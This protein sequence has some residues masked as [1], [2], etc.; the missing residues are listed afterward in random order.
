MNPSKKVY[1]QPMMQ[2]GNRTPDPTDSS[3]PPTGPEVLRIDTIVSGGDGITRHP[4]GFVV[5]V[6]RT[7]AGEQVEVNYIE[8]HKQ[9]RRARVIRVLESSPHRR[10]PPCPYYARCGGCQLQ[11]LDYNNAQLPAKA[12]IIRDSLRR[13]GKID[14]ALPEVEASEHEFG[15]R[16]RV[17]LELN[18]RS[19]EAVAGYHDINY[20]TV[21][22]G[23]DECP[24]AE[25][26]IND[27]WRALRSIWD[28]ATD[29]LPP[30]R[31]LRLTFRANSEG[32]VGLAIEGGRGPGRCGELLDITGGLFAVWVLDPRG[33]IT[34]RA[35][36]P[37]L[38][39]RIGAYT[40]PLAG[41]GF[42]QV[43]RETA[44]R[45]DSY[46]RGQC[47]TVRGGRVVDAYCGY[48]IR[49]LELARDGASVVG[50]EHD[51]Y[52]VKTANQI[53]GQNGIPARFVMGDVERFLGRFTPADT[54]IV[55]PP[56]RGVTRPVID[57]LMERDV[58]RIVY[59]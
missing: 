23:I 59:V 11:H 53:A 37:F 48:G 54:V 44:A 35:G 19:C 40:V 43:N 27:A 38:D 7:A 16:N 3:S 25:Q 31:E 5:F 36:L 26:P 55:N 42:L 51:R 9:W 49:A 52:A 56:R 21:L 4:D 41:T 12:A 50:I 20:P 14:A 29:C 34:D 10:E 2:N 24:L 6:P 1:L 57:I 45:L 15:Y 28:R 13:I 17:S 18:R 58:S 33:N 32:A 22:V 8:V 39:E 46:V 47:G 30:G